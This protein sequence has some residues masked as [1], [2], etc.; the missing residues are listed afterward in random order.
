[1]KNLILA[2][3]LILSLCGGCVSTKEIREPE[4]TAYSQKQENEGRKIKES[5]NRSEYEAMTKYEDCVASV[6]GSGEDEI[7]L[8]TSAKKDSDGEFMW[9]DSQQWALAVKGD[10]NFY[11]LYDENI[12]GTPKL[13]VSECYDDGTEVTPVIRLTLSS[14]AGFEIREYRYQDKVF[15]EKVVYDMGAINELPVNKYY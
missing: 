11:V 5:D 13:N 4:A 1:M 6:I 15:E 7:I 9:D 3:V 2:I 8:L 14:S 10:S 12:K